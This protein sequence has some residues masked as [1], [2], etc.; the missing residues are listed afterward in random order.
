M[1]CNSGI[2]RTLTFF[3]VGLLCLVLI[4][5]FTVARAYAQSPTAITGIVVNGTNDY[6]V[7][8]GLPVVLY[9]FNNMGQ[10]VTTYDSLTDE[11]GRFVFDDVSLDNGVGYAL[12]VDYGGMSYSVLLAEE[13]LFEPISITIY[14]PTQDLSVISVSTHTLIIADINEKD[15]MIEA[16]EFVSLSNTSDFSLIPDLDTV[17]QGLFSFM[18]FS[19]PE[20]AADLDLQSDL[21]GGQI[22]PMGT[23]FA[24]TSPIAPGS[25]SVTYSYRFPYRG[26]TA[27]F[28]Q[29]LMQGAELYQV[30]IP[31]HENSPKVIGPME[32]SEIN[33]EGIDYTIWEARSRSPKQGLSVEVVDLPQMGIASSLWNRL[34]QPK[35]WYRAMPVCVG[36]V[37][38]FVLL[39]SIYIGIRSKIMGNSIGSGDTRDQIIEK[40]ALLDENAMT[41]QLSKR[42]YDRERLILKN[43]LLLMMDSGEFK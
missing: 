31:K 15:Q 1:H 8:A 25:H 7:D 21:V 26:D 37:L 40:I 38:L 11:V 4:G 23:G 17:S 28:K 18:R 41:G 16:V 39:Y 35:F 27:T 32:E 14:E 5:I 10:D 6:V 43:R 22:I 30:L 12:G 19:L 34:L 42:E 24:L 9:S 13:D 36:I 3:A 20:G 29:N 2:K 33:I